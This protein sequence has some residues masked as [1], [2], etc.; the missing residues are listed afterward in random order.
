MPLR[1]LL[2]AVT[3]WSMRVWL[4]GLVWPLVEPPV[5]DVA[6]DPP[7]DDVAPP[8]FLLPPVF[9]VPP[10]APVPP[11]DLE[12]PVDA[13]PPALAQ[14]P[15][16]VDPPT[17]MQVSEGATPLQPKTNALVM[18]IQ[19]VVRAKPAKDTS[20]F[21]CGIFGRKVSF[22]CVDGSQLCSRLTIRSVW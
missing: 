4:S 22:D 1:A 21:R 6:V 11:V 13:V 14:G 18:Q 15:V 12:P 5:D 2:C 3:N 9:L 10:T 17:P 7:A 20:E 8:V 19:K 16:P